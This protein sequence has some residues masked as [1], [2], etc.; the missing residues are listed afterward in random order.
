MTKFVAYFRVSTAKQGASGL[1]LEAQAQSVREYVRAAGGE[2]LAEYTE[3]ESGRCTTRPQLA[4]ALAACRLRGAT[5]LVAK[6]DR[7][8]RNAHFL[9]GLKESAVE[10]ICCDM[11]A[12]NRLTVG[13][14]AMVAEEEARLISVRTKQALEAA[15]AR[16]VRLG[17]PNLTR[18]RSAMG[19]AA[20]ARTRSDR[21]QQR[22][23]DL[24]PILAS[25]SRANVTAPTAIARELNQQN[26]PAPRG[27]Q[28][29]PVQVQRVL[30][31]VAAIG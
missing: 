24:A 21:A 13:I 7:L 23:R 4:A 15:K 9:L 18:E 3:V 30:Q 10:F 31:R 29:T 14:L 8:S 19:N 22:A 6:L 5:L 12:A 11:P 28:W 16:G 1:G 20:S 17:R 26:I 2:L 27:G 25:L